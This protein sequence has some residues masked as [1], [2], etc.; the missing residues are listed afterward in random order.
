[1]TTLPNWEE[2][3][4][5]AYAKLDI[6]LEKGIGDNKEEVCI[7]SNN[8]PPDAIRSA[9]KILG[10]TEG[11]SKPTRTVRWKTLTKNYGPFIAEDKYVQVMKHVMNVKTG[12]NVQLSKQAEIALFIY[13]NQPNKTLEFSSTFSSSFR[14]LFNI[15]VADIDISGFKNTLLRIPIPDPAYGF[16][17]VDGITTRLL[18]YTT[19]VTRL[20]ISGVNAGLIIPGIDKSTVV[21]NSS[22]QVPGFKTVNVPGAS[23]ASKWVERN[24]ETKYSLLDFSPNGD[25]YETES[26]SESESAY[27]GSSMSET[28][29]HSQ[30]GSELGSEAGVALDFD[31]YERTIRMN[32]TPEWIDVE[33]ESDAPSIKDFENLSDQERF[34]PLNYVLTAVEQWRIILHALSSNFRSVSRLPSVNDNILR[35]V[36]DA[37][38]YSLQLNNSVPKAAYSLLEYASD[39][40]I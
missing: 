1:M 16:V 6:S 21:V 22:V 35:T 39:R 17:T 23:W 33:L 5:Q 38:H 37:I 7:I 24:G 27:E 31:E 36:A 14:T 32:D 8:N 25:I 12:N 40:R 19:P 28:S 11:F 15:D 9:N 26:E 30:Y 2:Y 4:K 29:S 10:A 18:H 13:A 20:V 3:I 34:L